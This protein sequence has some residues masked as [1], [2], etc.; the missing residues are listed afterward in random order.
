LKDE[1][2]VLK[3]KKKRPTFKPSKR[4]ERAGKGKGKPPGKR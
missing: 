1:I 4:E 2:A 3:G